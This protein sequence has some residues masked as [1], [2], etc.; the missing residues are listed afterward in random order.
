MTEDDQFQFILD[1]CEKMRKKN[2]PDLMELWY[3]QREDY[4]KQIFGERK[5]DNWSL[6][7]YGSQPHKDGYCLYTY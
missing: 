2:Q 7:S 5:D 6:Y 4:R 3:R 1:Q